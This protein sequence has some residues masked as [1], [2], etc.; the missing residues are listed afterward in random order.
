MCERK[1]DTLKHNKS[2]VQPLAMSLLEI[3]FSFFFFT[4]VSSNSFVAFFFPCTLEKIFILAVPV[5][6]FFSSFCYHSCYFTGQVKVI[7]TELD[8]WA[9]LM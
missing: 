8:P 1:A 4:Y 5:E 2:K 9:F 3:I 6:F 7:I